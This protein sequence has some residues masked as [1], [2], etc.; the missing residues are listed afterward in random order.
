[1]T[2]RDAPST[3]SQGPHKHSRRA[4]PAVWSP[5]L[6]SAPV[7]GPCPHF[8]HGQPVPGELARFPNYLLYVS[9]FSLG[10]NGSLCIGVFARLRPPALCFWGPCSKVRVGLSWAVGST[11][12]AGIQ[13]GTDTQVFTHPD[14]QWNRSYRGLSLPLQ[15]PLEIPVCSRFSR[16]RS[17]ALAVATSSPG[18]AL[19]A[20]TAAFMGCG[21]WG[22]VWPA[23]GEV[24][25]SWQQDY[26]PLSY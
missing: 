24:L 4:H 22:H 23:E 17:G 5:G 7:P 26:C 16:Y 14:L 12:S 19:P 3:T 10:S 13:G 1:M 8:A 21:W 9:N 11:D 18:W 20:G 6:P 25:G 2:V 15:P